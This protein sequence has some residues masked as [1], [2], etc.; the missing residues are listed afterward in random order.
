MLDGLHSGQTFLRQQKH[1]VSC[2]TVA[3]KRAA[4][5]DVNASKL[6]CHVQL[7]VRVMATALKNNLNFSM[8]G[9]VC[10]CYW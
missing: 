6:S 2:C 4:L 9:Q 8:S 1:A 10:A 3:V 7:F 5:E